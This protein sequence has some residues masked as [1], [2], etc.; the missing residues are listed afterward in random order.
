LDAS[1]SHHEKGRSDQVTPAGAFLPAAHRRVPE[2][3]G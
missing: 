3:H 1:H 2:N